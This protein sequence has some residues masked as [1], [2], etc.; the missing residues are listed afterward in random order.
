IMRLTAGL[1]SGPVCLAGSEP[2]G[3][4]DTYATLAARLQELAATL[5]LRVLDRKAEGRPLPF[6]EQDEAAATY[7]EK[8]Q[9]Q[10]RLLDPAHAAVELERQVRAL[11][12]HIGA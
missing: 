4:H 12:P 10:D 6:V 8:I 2:I 9:P 5:L 11:R 3:P 7:A 1:D